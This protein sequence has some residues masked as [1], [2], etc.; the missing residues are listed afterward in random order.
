MF[1]GLCGM[2]DKEPANSDISFTG[3]F[4]V[5]PIYHMHIS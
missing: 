4:F 1:F 2:Q 5:Y 3:T